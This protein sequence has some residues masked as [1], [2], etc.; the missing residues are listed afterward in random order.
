MGRARDRDK[1]HQQAPPSQLRLHRVRDAS[2]A[3]ER[4]EGGSQG[5]RQQRP[6]LRQAFSFRLRRT[7]EERDRR[8]E[9]DR[10]ARQGRRADERGGNRE[11]ARVAQASLGSHRLLEG[12][13]RDVLH[14]EGILAPSEGGGLPE[15]QECRP[16]YPGSCQDSHSSRRAGDRSDGGS[17]K[18]GSNRRLQGYERESED[19]K[20]QR[21][22]A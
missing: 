7:L 4:G 6:V 12:S 19:K 17:E 1:T 14:T 21:G 10:R 8:G 20:H 9:E 16:E 15:A 11:P 5:V 3:R 22:S 13:A 2:L 18:D